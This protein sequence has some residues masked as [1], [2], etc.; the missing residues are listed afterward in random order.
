RFERA[1]FMY[2]R[3]KSFNPRTNWQMIDVPDAGHDQRKMAPAAQ[4]FLRSQEE[5]PRRQRTT[6]TPTSHLP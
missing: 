4:A 3:V 2:R 1:A 5:R 6:V